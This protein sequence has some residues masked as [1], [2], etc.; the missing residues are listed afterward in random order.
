MMRIE[1]CR[2]ARSGLRWTVNELA[3][4]SGISPRTIARFELGG[5][6]AQQTLAA[7]KTTLEDAGAQFIDGEE[8]VGVLLRQRARP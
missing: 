8:A 3:R 5:R 2:M 6:V 4:Q 1:H 7:I